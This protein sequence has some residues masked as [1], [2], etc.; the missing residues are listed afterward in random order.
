MTESVAPAVAAAIARLLPL[1]EDDA[2]RLCLQ[3]RL[4]GWG[5]ALLACE[6]DDYL[7]KVPATVREEYEHYEFFIMGRL[8]EIRRIGWCSSHYSLVAFPS[9]LEQSRALVQERFAALA[10]TTGDGLGWLEPGPWDALTEEQQAMCKPKF[11]EDGLQY[12]SM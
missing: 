5:V 7:F 10:V 1:C 4:A 8:L 2:V 3:K 6:G 11:V 9:G 12:C